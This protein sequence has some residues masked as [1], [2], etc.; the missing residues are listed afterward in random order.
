[1][2]EAGIRFVAAAI[3]AARQTGGLVDPTLVGEIECARSGSIDA[4]VH[5]RGERRPPIYVSAFG[6]RSARIAARLADGVW[7]LADPEKAPPVIDAYKEKREELGKEPGEII[8]QRGFSWAEDDDAAMEG[9]RVWKSACAS[10]RGWSRPS[11]ASRTPPAPIPKARY[12]C[13]GRRCCRPC[14]TCASSPD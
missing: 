9:A 8:L 6:P 4:V 1:V 10:S 11:S 7:T 5:T 3:D 13:T 14:A 12:G 2:T